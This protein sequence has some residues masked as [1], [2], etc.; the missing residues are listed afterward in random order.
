MGRV[1]VQRLGR[2][3]RIGHLLQGSGWGDEGQRT[4]TLKEDAVHDRAIELLHPDDFAD[5]LAYA[6][7]VSWLDILW[8]G[9]LLWLRLWWRIVH[10]LADSCPLSPKAL[11][12]CQPLL[13]QFGRVVPQA[14]EDGHPLQRD[15]IRLLQLHHQV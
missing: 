15:G 2:T 10:C 1:E 13:C 4:L 5:P 7:P 12:V 9:H 3:Q 6:D 14:V 11:I 8:H